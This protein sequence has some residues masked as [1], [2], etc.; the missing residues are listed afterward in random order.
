MYSN[1]RCL[2]ICYIVNN[3]VIFIFI[4]VLGMVDVFVNFFIDS[5]FV[6]EYNN[7]FNIIGIFLNGKFE[8]DRS[9]YVLL[10]IR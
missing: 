10:M 2:L 8:I 5:F 1:R 3:D 6:S 4:V 7:G 9:F